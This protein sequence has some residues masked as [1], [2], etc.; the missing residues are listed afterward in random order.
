MAVLTNVVHKGT[1]YTLGENGYEKCCPYA[2]EVYM[3]DG[4]TVEDAIANV[5]FEYGT[6]GNWYYRK[7]N[8]GVLE[9]WLE[10]N[11]RIGNTKISSGAWGGYTSGYIT[12]PNYP[13][14]FVQP[15]ATYIHSGSMDDSAAGDYM[16]IHAGL[17]TT[18]FDELK[19]RP[20]QFKYWRGTAH[21]FGHPTIT[22]YAI[23]HWK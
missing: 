18:R 1:F 10:G 4:A 14:E 3:S 5:S 7:W 16:I 9:C 11:Y 15:P 19:K 13:I 20:P 6:S 17:S 23:G 2:D 12:L 21:T 8:N 22:C